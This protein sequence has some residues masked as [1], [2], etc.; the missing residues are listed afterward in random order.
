[1]DTYE[2]LLAYL[3]KLP[4]A[5]SG[6]GGHDSTLRAAC[7]AVRFGLS[8]SDQLRAMQWWNSNKC[9]PPWSEKELAHKLAS[10]RGKAQFGE[11]AYS[12]K[13]RSQ[14]P[15]WGA[16]RAEV[17][18]FKQQLAQANAP[19]PPIAPA[20]PFWFAWY[21]N[22]HNRAYFDPQDNA[23]AFKWMTIDELREVDPRAAEMAVLTEHIRDESREKVDNH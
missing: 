5:I 9:N 23:C 15:D 16:V 12:G 2:R 11:R 13:S 20:E 14:P 4:P 10:A 3:E 7:E 21:R 22:D 6:A 18:Q 1:M 19:Q 17:E 8:E